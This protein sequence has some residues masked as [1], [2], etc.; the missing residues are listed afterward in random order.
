MEEKKQTPI[1]SA[2]IRELNK[3]AGKDRILDRKNSKSA[4]MLSEQAFVKD[5]T[6][7]SESPDKVVDSESA[8]ESAA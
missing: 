1:K 5:R 8:K 6:E 7:W 2:T 3:E 4:I